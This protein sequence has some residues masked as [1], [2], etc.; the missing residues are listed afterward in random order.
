[1]NAQLETIR[2]VFP[3]DTIFA[4]TLKTLPRTKPVEPAHEA[5]SPRF[6]FPNFEPENRGVPDS[7]LHD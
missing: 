2:T 7:P 1:M 5:P 3:G 6:E 4:V